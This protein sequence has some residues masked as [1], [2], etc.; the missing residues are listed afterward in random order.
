M[1]LC[2]TC[3]APCCDSPI[4]KWPNSWTEQVI[5]WVMDEHGE[6]RDWNNIEDFLNTMREKIQQACIPNIFFSWTHNPERTLKLSAIEI[7]VS[8]EQ[9]VMQF[10]FRVFFLCPDY[11]D[12]KCTNYKD[13]PAVC[14]RFECED[15]WWDNASRETLTRVKQR[16]KNIFP[17]VDSAI[18]YIREKILNN[19]TQQNKF[20]WD[21]L[22]ALHTLAH[23]VWIENLVISDDGGYVD[24]LYLW[25]PVRLMFQNGLLLE[26]TGLIDDEIHSNLLEELWLEEREVPRKWNTWIHIPASISTLLWLKEQEYV[27]RAV[28]FNEE[29]TDYTW[30]ILS[31]DDDI[32][33][34]QK[35][36]LADVL[37]WKESPKVNKIKIDNFYLKLHEIRKKLSWNK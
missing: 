24:Y 2:D 26:D 4:I 31:L 8:E 28:F 7:E 27:L 35:R 18:L 37:S 11:L 34:S 1:S 12:G 3:S 15:I 6:Y 9:E 10:L 30:H 36:S 23:R 22:P 19:L 13:R 25:S 5:E 21:D 33:D 14:R 17:D 20:Q 16:G 29:T 32:I